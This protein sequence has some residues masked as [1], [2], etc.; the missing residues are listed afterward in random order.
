MCIEFLALAESVGLNLV[1][2]QKNAGPSTNLALEESTKLRCQGIL[3]LAVAHLFGNRPVWHPR[4]AL[5]RTEAV[6]ETDVRMPSD[7]C[8]VLRTPPNVL[9]ISHVSCMFLVWFMILLFPD[10][11]MVQTE[12]AAGPAALIERGAFMRVCGRRWVQSA[13]CL[14]KAWANRHNGTMGTE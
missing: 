13:Q 7:L 14:D 4:P 12:A 10:Q 2:V 9:H 1:R 8:N 3:G 11:V 5:D 6:S